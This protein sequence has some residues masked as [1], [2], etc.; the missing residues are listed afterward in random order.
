MAQ[1]KVKGGYRTECKGVDENG[2]V[3]LDKL[4]VIGQQAEYTPFIVDGDDVIHG[5]VGLVSDAPAENPKV[6]QSSDTGKLP[7]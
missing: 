5:K 4:I 1:T 2:V 7:T 6:E 3:I